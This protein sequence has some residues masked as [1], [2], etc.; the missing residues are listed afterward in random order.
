M[1][2]KSYILHNLV[3]IDVLAKFDYRPLGIFLRT[4]TQD[5]GHTYARRKVRGASSLKDRRSADHPG[6]TVSL[7]MNGSGKSSKHDGKAAT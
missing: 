1:S 4:L 2:S 3:L 6:R 5:P 7:G